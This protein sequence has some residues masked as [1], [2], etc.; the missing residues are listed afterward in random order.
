MMQQTFVFIAMVLMII[1]AITGILMTWSKSIGIG[2][3]GGC[4]VGAV[5]SVI[6]GISSVKVLGTLNESK[7][8]DLGIPLADLFPS[9]IA[10]IISAIFIVYLVGRVGVS[11][12][13]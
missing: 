1:G 6:G 11:N 8:D 5:A 4:L 13:T 7:L 10:G 3:F 9:F 12:K 2:K